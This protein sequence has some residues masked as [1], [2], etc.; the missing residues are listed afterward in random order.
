MAADDDLAVEPKPPRRGVARARGVGGAQRK[1]VDIGAIERRHV[2]RRRDV[3]REHAAERRGKRDALRRQRREID[4]ARKARARL[5]G[6]DD[7]E[8]LLL[9]RRA[10]DRGD[11]IVARSAFVRSGRS[12]PGSYHD[13]AARRKTFAVGGHQNPAVGAARAAP[14]A[15]SP[16]LWARRRAF[17]EAHR[18][19]L[20]R[21][22]AATRPC[23]RASQRCDGSAP[24]LLPASR[25][26][27]GSP[28]V[29]QP[30]IAASIR[31]GSSSTGRS[32]LMP[33]A[34]VS[35]G[36]IAMPCAVD[37]A[38][39]RRACRRWRRCGRCRCRRW[40]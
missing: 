7:F 23:A 8:E 4:V 21:A 28:M 35:P 31:P 15:N 30:A 40:R 22:R 27:S 13:L 33:K 36:E 1:A 18:N 2:D 38:M 10:A 34:A 20:R 12:W 26:I 39:L 19:D 3:M 11:E 24:S 6:G 37:A 32:P 17:S 5:L 9:P 25:S 14:A 16:R 29:S